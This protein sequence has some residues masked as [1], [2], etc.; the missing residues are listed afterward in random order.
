MRSDG[1]P[2]R[3]VMVTGYKLLEIGCGDYYG[4]TLSG[5]GLYLLGDFTVTHNSGKGYSLDNTPE[6][7]AMKK[8]SKAVWDS[9]G[10]QN[11]TENPWIQQE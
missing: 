7:V 9:A 8:E 4:F 6:A 2:T 1:I 5:D 10:D 11:A 3:G